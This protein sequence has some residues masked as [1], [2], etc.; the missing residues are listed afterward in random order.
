MEEMACWKSGA[1][2]PNNPYTAE[3]PTRGSSRKRN[4]GRIKFPFTT[5]YDGNTT[6]TGGLS[7]SGVRPMTV[8]EALSLM[9]AFGALVAV[10]SQT[11][12]K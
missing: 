3:I 1:P 11:K 6:D 4:K 5:C 10:L 2:H 8:F 9:I 7:R 12:R